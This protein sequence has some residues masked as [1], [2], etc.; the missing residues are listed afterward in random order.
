VILREG[1]KIIKKESGIV[2]Q[3]KKIHGKKFVIVSSEDGSR[4]AL[5]SMKGLDSYFTP[6]CAHPWED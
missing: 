3:V 1:D 2:N 4:S 5:M 6:F